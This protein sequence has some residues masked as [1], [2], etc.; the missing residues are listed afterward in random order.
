MGKMGMAAI[1]ATLNYRLFGSYCV[2]GMFDSEECKKKLDNASRSRE[3]F[4]KEFHWLQSD[5]RF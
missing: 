5:K 4:V 3:N 1:D 2:S